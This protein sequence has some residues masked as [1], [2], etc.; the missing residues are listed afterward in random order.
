[1]KAPELGRRVNR[2][3]AGEDKGMEEKKAVHRSSSRSLLPI[4]ATWRRQNHTGFSP[5]C[6]TYWFIDL[7]QVP[8]MMLT[9]SRFTVRSKGNSEADS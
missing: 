5:I 9:P 8:G 1:M 3:L 2:F 7:E 4:W 6:T